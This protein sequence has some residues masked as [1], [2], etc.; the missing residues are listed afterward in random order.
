MVTVYIVPLSPSRTPSEEQIAEVFEY[1]TFLVGSE[2]RLSDKAQAI[3]IDQDKVDGFEM[4]PEYE[5]LDDVPCVQL[6]EVVTDPST[7]SK[8]PTTEQREAVQQLF[9]AVGTRLLAYEM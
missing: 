3:G 9:G 7:R 2:L 6:V 8:L 1:C 5:V 4:E